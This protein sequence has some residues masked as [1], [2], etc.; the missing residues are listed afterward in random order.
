MGGVDLPPTDMPAVFGIVEKYVR[1]LQERPMAANTV[2]TFY[3]IADWQKI[4]KH[5]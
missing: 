3:T 2:S 4:M 1:F 5:H